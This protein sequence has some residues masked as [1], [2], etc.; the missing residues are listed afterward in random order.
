M[1][2]AILGS[3]QRMIEDEIGYFLSRRWV[4]GTLVETVGSDE[5][6][7]GSDRGMAALVSARP[8]ALRVCGGRADGHDNRSGQRWNSTAD[9]A[10]I[11]VTTTVTD[12]SNRSLPPRHHN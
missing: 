12:S 1:W 8:L 9:P 3:A 6:L 11:A 7:V 10:V 4:A 2:P 5:R